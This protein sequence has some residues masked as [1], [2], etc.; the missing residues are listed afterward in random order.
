MLKSDEYRD[1]DFGFLGFLVITDLVLFVVF[2]L[3]EDEGF[4]GVGFRI[5]LNE[6]WIMVRGVA[7]VMTLEGW[8]K[9]TERFSV[10]LGTVVV[11][12]GG[13]FCGEDLDGEVLVDD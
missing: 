4:D 9:G 5:A 3:G 7:S 6:G 8:V 11:V 2:E 1:L 10:M 13:D 12:C